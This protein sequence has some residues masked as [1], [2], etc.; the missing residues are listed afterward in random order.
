MAD[1]RMNKIMKTSSIIGALDII[2][3]VFVCVYMHII[4]EQL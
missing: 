3:S 1:M 2:P 4:C